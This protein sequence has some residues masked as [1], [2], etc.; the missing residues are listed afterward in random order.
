MRIRFG[1]INFS[2]GG[3]ARQA[4]LTARESRL[5]DSFLFSRK[6]LVTLMCESYNFLENKKHSVQDAHLADKKLAASSTARARRISGADS[7]FINEKGH[8]W[9]HELS[10]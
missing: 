8:G 1:E 9:Y 2:M 7:L 6:D 3:C 5:R 4:V 10:V